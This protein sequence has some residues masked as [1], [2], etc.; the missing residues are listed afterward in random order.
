MVCVLVHSPTESN[1]SSFAFLG[2]MNESQSDHIDLKGFEKSSDGVE[3]MI[4][5]CYSGSLSITSDNIDQL[6]HAATHLQI[7]EGVELCCNFLLQSCFISNCIDVY[8]IADLYSLTTVLDSVRSF[9]SKNFLR[10]MLEAREQFEQLNYDQIRRELLRDTLDMHDYDEYHVFTMIC[11]WIEANRSERDKYAVELFPLVRFMLIS[12]E[13]LTDEVRGHALIR[14]DEQSRT[15]VEDALCFYALPKRQPLNNDLQCR[16]RNQSALVA[17]GEV[18]LFTLNTM[19]GGWETLCQAPLE[20]NYP[21]SIRFVSA[22]LLSSTT[23]MRKECRNNPATDRL[24]RALYTPYE[25][26]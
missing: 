18:E 25:G 5:F 9:I 15:L 20:E 11:R 21:V 6:L 14:R 13:Q 1:A 12:P 2:Q 7:T 19:E 3:A 23:M 26:Q 17:I 10:L 24:T 4:H 16:I 22:D 8:K